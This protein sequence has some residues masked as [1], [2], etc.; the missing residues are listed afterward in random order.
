VGQQEDAMVYTTSYRCRLW[1][2]FYSLPPNIPVG[3]VSKILLYPYIEGLEPLP[4]GCRT[5]TRRG[6]AIDLLSVLPLRGSN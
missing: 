3:F 2:E 5:T 1:G 6:K 4:T